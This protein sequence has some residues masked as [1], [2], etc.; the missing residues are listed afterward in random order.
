M[1]VNT[2][3]LDRDLC[4]ITGFIRESPDDTL[5]LEVISLILNYCTIY[6]NKNVTN[7]ITQC[8]PDSVEIRYNPMPTMQS[9]GTIKHDSILCSMIRD[10]GCLC[11]V[12]ITLMSSIY[13]WIEFD[14]KAP[15]YI[16]FFIFFISCAGLYIWNV[17]INLDDIKHIMTIPIKYVNQRTLLFENLF[18]NND[19]N[20]SMHINGYHL[21]KVVAQNGG[22]ETVQ[23][24]REAKDLLVDF[25]N[26]ETIITP[27][28]DQNDGIYNGWLYRFDFDILFDFENNNNMLRYI[29]ICQEFIND[30]IHD[31]KQSFEIGIDYKI[32]L[33]DIDLTFYHSNTSDYFIVINSDSTLIMKRVKIV[34]RILAVLSM[35]WLFRILSAC[36][37]KRKK[38]VITKYVSIIDKL[39]TINTS[40]HSSNNNELLSVQS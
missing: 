30:N 10:I 3:I 1:S 28:I 29:Q 4:A 19:Y 22:R 31:Q 33:S 2:H 11:L 6:T 15:G 35:L 21:G 16:I 13:I 34:M 27:S 17:W 25:E 26:C 20:I 40:K 8:I 39:S 37:V 38:Y 12:V 32:R 23:T 24:F 9:L 5:P 14:D 36:F 18:S 7:Q